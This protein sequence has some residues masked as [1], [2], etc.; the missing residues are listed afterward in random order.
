MINKKYTQILSNNIEK[1]INTNNFELINA[2]ANPQKVL[3]LE[4]RRYIGNKAKL[5][6]WIM[7]TIIKEIDNNVKSFLDI[8]AGTA[9][10][11]KT[12]A[13]YFPRIIINDILSSNHV[14]YKAFF[15][16][17]PCDFKKISDFLL[18]YNAINPNDLRE[19]YFS[20]HFGNK[21]FDNQ[22]AKLIGYIRED[23][24]ASH[25]DLTEKEYALLLTILIYNIDKLAN[26]VGH[27][28]AY[29][30]K[31]IK[32]KKLF[33]HNIAQ[34]PIKNIE[35]YK[36]NANILARKI[37]ADVAYI[38]PPYNSRQ[39]NR[40]YHI[41][42]NLVEWQKPQLFGVA[43]KPKS[44]NNSLYCTTKARMAFQDLVENLDT[45]YL[46]VSY[47]NTYNSKSSSSEN[48]IQL[49]EIEDILCKKGKTKIFE[50]SHKF[51]NTG[52]TDFNDHKELLYICK[53]EAK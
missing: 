4:N 39:Y 10:I 20:E 1:K 12:S 48:K 46:V 23:I 38:D 8:F 36:E 17:S 9:S 18:R 30:K 25:K 11:A 21:F 41:Y 22:N 24:E 15:D 7:N 2:I 49:K 34:Y 45:K 40:F 37:K 13:M 50:C 19:N 32:Y 26:T 47:N 53:V 43:L 5:A 42:E 31:E 33:L 28:D 14:I 27:F 6:N 29:I 3:Q 35:I 51:F 44:E 52:K 16:S